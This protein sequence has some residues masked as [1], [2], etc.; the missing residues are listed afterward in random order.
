MNRARAW[1][2]VI[3]T[4][5]LAP[6]LWAAQPSDGYCADAVD[7]AMR[8]AE[9]RD[10][11]KS[12]ASIETSIRQSPEVFKQQYPDLEP[13]DMQAL[14]LQVFRN[15]WS[16]FGAARETARSCARRLGT[17]LPPGVAPPA[18]PVIADPQA[19]T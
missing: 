11:G 7:F 1:M 4:L 18:A 12:Q 19:R 14:V 17:A 13:A 8:T 3:V 5:A 15:R 2:A 16:R 6:P 9:R 10:A